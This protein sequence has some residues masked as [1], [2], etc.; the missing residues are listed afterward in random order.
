MDRRE[1]AAVPGWITTVVVIG[2]ALLVVGAALAFVKP[3]ILLGPGNPVTSGVRVYAG[4]LFSR[5]L[6][7]AVLLIASLMPRFR[8]NLS[9]MIA[10]YGLIQLLDAIMDCV[11]GRWTVLPPV[12]LL[13]LLF[14]WAWVR[15]PKD[16]EQGS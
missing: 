10:L 14:A 11:E 1:S 4:Y 6:A 7:L 5:N 9:G 13:G 3:S 15:M 12:V 8:K 2:A 16:R